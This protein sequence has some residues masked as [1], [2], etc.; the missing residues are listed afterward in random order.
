MKTQDKIVNFF[1][2]YTALS[3][4]ISIFAWAAVG[5]GFVSVPIIYT[6]G[7][8]AAG[9]AL[10]GLSYMLGLLMVYQLTKYGKVGVAA[11]AVYPASQ[12][13][14]LAHSYISHGWYYAPSAGS[15]GTIPA[16][17]ISLAM[18]LYLFSKTNRPL[19]LA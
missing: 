9:W 6:T 3:I 19:R 15:Q 13:L 17:V 16:A 18:L 12:A 8:G 5:L 7:I 14:T 11:F 10:A 4:V 2:I 1:C